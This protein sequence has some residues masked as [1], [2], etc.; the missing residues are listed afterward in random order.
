MKFQLKLGV[1]IV[2]EVRV[3]LL[4]LVGGGWWVVVGLNE[5]NTKLNSSKRLELKYEFG[6]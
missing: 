6:N 2:N 3:K 1:D 5:I 4:V